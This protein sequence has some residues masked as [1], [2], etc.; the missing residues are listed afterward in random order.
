MPPFHGDRVRRS[1]AP[2]RITTQSCA[3]GVLCVRF[4]LLVVRG[5]LTPCPNQATKNSK[6]NSRNYKNN[7]AQKEAALSI[8]ASA[9]KAASA[10]MASAVSPSHSITNSGPA[11]S[12]PSQSSKPS[13]KNKK[14][15][16]NSNCRNKSR[17]LFGFIGPC[18]G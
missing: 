17:T 16:A 9:K 14:P 12:R 7:P 18:S 13:S 6:R 4:F 15:Q 1:H 11:S 5:G 3:L 8:F 2:P 10:S